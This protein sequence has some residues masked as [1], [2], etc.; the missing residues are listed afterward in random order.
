MLMTW[1]DW[2]ELESIYEAPGSLYAIEG[3]DDAAAAIDGAYPLPG[4]S[5]RELT[6]AS[7]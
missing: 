1:R 4:L 2:Q 7:L 3:N 6:H 5:I